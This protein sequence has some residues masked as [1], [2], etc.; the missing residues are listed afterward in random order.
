MFL[1]GFFSLHSQSFS[2]LN[3][4]SCENPGYKLIS[5]NVKESMYCYETKSSLV[6]LAWFCFFSSPKV[7]AAWTLLTLFLMFIID[8]L[9]SWM[10]FLIT[11]L[12]WPL[13]VSMKQS[14]THNLSFIY[15]AFVNAFQ[16][17]LNATAFQGLPVCSAALTFSLLKNKAVAEH[18]PKNNGSLIHTE[19][20]TYPG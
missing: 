12:V 4:A 13:F 18:P 19:K 8:K 14:W 20:H 3:T 11:M 15:T 10:A 6:F 5:S 1:P 17:W 16:V 9:S 7:P 2:L